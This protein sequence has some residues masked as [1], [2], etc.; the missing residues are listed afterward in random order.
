MAVLPEDRD[1][2][3]DCKCGKGQY[4]DYSFNSCRSCPSEKIGAQTVSGTTDS[5]NH[6]IENCYL[7]AGEYFDYPDYILST[8]VV[9]VLPSDCFYSN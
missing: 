2:F 8:G 5:D 3:T 9:E 7:P 4:Y 1:E 6:H